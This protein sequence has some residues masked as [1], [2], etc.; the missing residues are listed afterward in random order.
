MRGLC[1]WLQPMVVPVS[2]ATLPAG[3]SILVGAYFSSGFPV[4]VPE[5][6]WLR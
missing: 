1:F 4:G 5:S 2:C 3:P 6:S